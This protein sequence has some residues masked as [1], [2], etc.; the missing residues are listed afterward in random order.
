[1]SDAHIDLSD[2][3]REAL[4][5]AIADN[6][7][8]VA[9]FVERLDLVNDLLDGVDVAYA[10]ADDRMAADVADT[11]ATLA[12]AGDGL[13]T[14]ETARLAERVGEDA[15][16]LDDALATLVDLQ[17]S[18]TL[19]DLASLADT[20]SLATAAV[21]DEMVTTLASTGASLGELADV[22]ADDDVARGLE[23][24]LVALGEADAPD[25]AEAL[26]ALGLLRALRE[27]EVKRGLGVLV[28]VARA[29]GSADRN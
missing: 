25:E 15:A 29:L 1:M 28:S 8:A 21:D 11:G 12:E 22:A 17:R 3:R 4:E 7:E 16:D 23:T 9:R 10:A 2:P 20:A 18:G 19:D 26:G 6:P 14:P 27:A 13:A 24:L 5:D